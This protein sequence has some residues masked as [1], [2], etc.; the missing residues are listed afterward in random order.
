MM[1]KGL[2]LRRGVAPIIATLI[3]IAIAVVGGTIISLYT[4]EVFATA[5]ISG[6][7]SIEL[8]EIL[9]YDA[10]DSQE[11]INFDDQM[12]QTYSGGLSDGQKSVG[13]RVAIYVQNHSIQSVI[14]NELRFAG[15]VYTFSQNVGTLMPYFMGSAPAVGEYAILLQAPDELLN[16]STPIIEAGQTVTLV[17]GLDDNIKI[18][19]DGQV[20]ITTNHGA[21][22]LGTAKTGNQES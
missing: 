1:C 2:H 17:I 9:G 16:S 6:G 18:G 19:R 14:I 10:T 22:F 3:L 12:L 5:Q 8:L 7:P 11:L 4:N 20:K 13:D 21:V 15:T